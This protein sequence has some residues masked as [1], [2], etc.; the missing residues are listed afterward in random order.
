MYQQI[1]SNLRK[2]LKLFNP[3]ISRADGINPVEANVNLGEKAGCT[4]GWC[5]DVCLAI[6]DPPFYYGCIDAYTCRCVKA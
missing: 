2:N 1:Q 3:L 4:P 6:M 5:L